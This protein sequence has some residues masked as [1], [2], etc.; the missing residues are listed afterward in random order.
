M[1]RFIPSVVLASFVAG[2]STEC[3]LGDT[4]CLDASDDTALLS[5]RASVRRHEKNATPLGSWKACSEGPEGAECCEPKPWGKPITFTCGNTS[6]HIECAYN[7]KGSNSSLCPSLPL[8]YCD[9]SAGDKRCCSP[10]HGDWCAQNGQY[11]MCPHCGGPLCHCPAKYTPHTVELL[12]AKRGTTCPGSLKACSGNQC[13]DGIKQTLWKT[14][15]GSCR[16]AA[17][18][19]WCVSM[20]VIEVVTSTGPI[21]LVG[22]PG[23]SATSA[24]HAPSDRAT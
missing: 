13:C 23:A 2:S 14:R 5:L 22:R 6:L 7:T 20:T 1:T 18:E 3:S 4:E 10:S 11:L 12:E 24:V 17:K 8:P 15:S 21:A 9:P 19:G 16:R